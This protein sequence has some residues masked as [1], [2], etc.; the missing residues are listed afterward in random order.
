MARKRG[1]STVQQALRLLAYLA[2]HPEGVGAKEVA[3]LLG[4]SL[5][6]AYALL[7]SLMEEG[8]VVKEEG[9]FRLAR[10]R[11]APLEPTPLEEALEEL[12]LRTRERCYLALLTP[13]GVRLKT[14]GRQGQLHPLGEALPP[15]WHALALGKV[16]LAFGD[17]PLPPLTPKTPYTLTD[18]LALEEELKRVRASGL[19]VEMEEYALGVS[20]V[21]VPLLSPEG[22]LLGAL[23]VKVPSRRF[24]FAFGRLARALAEVARV[25]AQVLPEEEAPTPPPALPEPGR[26]ER[27]DPPEALRRAA[28]LPDPRAAH[29]ASLEDPEAFWEDFARGF[30]W[31]KPW[32]AVFRREDRTWFAGGLTNVALNALDRHLPEKAQQVALLTLDGEGRLGKWTYKEVR[33][34][35]SRLAG[36]F[37]TLGVGRGDRVALYLPTGLEAALAALACARIGAVHAALPLGLGPEALRRRLEDLRPR[38]LVAADAYFYRGQPVRVREVVEAAIQGLDLKVLWH[39]RGSPEFL[40]RLY[41]ARPAEPEPVPAAHPLF[42]LYTSGSTGKPKGVVHGHGG[43]MVGVAWAL[44]HVFDLKPGEV[45]HTTADLFWIVGHS[46]GLYAPLLLGGTSLLVEDRPDHPSPGAFYERLAHLGVDVLLTSPAVLRTLRRHGEARPTGLRLA[47]SVGEVLSPEIW[48]WTREHLAWPVDNWWQ[49]E[50]GAPALA[51]PPAL[52]AKPGHVGLPLPGVEARVVDEEGRPL[53]P[54][55]KGHLV[56][57]ATGPA[58][59]V[60]L[61]GGRS[62]WRGGLY[63]TGDLAEMDEEGY[64]RILGRTEEVIKVGEARIGPAEVEAV[65]LTHPQVAEAAAVGVPGETGEEIAVFVV[66]QAREFPEELKPLLAEKLKAHI[67]RHLGP[68]PPPKVFFRER[69]PR[70]RSGKILRRLLKAELLGL[71]PGDT[72]GLEEDYGA[73]KAP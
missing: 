54:G 67:L 31:E 24:P 45:F 23:G 53:P 25:S 48:R 60:D 55:A 28:N 69:L 47:A 43:Y 63:W 18:P 4:K 10:Q 3:R 72:S 26:V 15:E 11:P 40:D 33:E 14:R 16:L 30:A 5:S 61:Q 51:T 71:D 35:A 38:L 21:A 59:M 64:F 29:R 19:A 62:P 57:C 1:L 58:H 65:L 52:P 22:R 46:F 73:G 34:L 39:V 50:L 9:G 68:V 20:G 42:I 12:Y 17:F 27:I 6:S 70:T 56:L 8:F 37:R 13:E 49:T 66:P 2:D 7:H 36:L 32:K 41:E 44:R